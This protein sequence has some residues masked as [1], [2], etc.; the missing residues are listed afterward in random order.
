MKSGATEVS[1]S[2]NFWCFLLTSNTQVKHGANDLGEKIPVK[3]AN[4]CIELCDK[5][6]SPKRCVRAITTL[7]GKLCYLRSHGNKEVANSP[8]YNSF[9]LV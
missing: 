8:G 6:E 3:D 1:I 5:K 7:D 4:E 2:A 9:H